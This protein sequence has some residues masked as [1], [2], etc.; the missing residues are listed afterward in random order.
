MRGSGPPA[1]G[2]RLDADTTFVRGKC[3]IADGQELI[4]LGLARAVAEAGL[5]VAGSAADGDAALA[6]IERRRPDVAV[7]DLD[8]RGLDG[9]EIC[10]HLVR[11]GSPTRVVVHSARRD[12]R[13]AEAALGAGAC[14]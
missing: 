14:G 8:L 4:R 13:H 2:V 9:L 11:S 1:T 10:D 5:E 7:L 6:L 3:A 12:P